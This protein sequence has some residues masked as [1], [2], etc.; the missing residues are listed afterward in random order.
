M[1]CLMLVF[2]VAPA[3]CLQGYQ[4]TLEQTAT[5]RNPQVACLA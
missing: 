5:L 2:S 4:G 1:Q 3:G